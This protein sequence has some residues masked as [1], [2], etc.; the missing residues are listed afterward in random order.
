MRNWLDRPE[1]VD[2]AVEGC[3]HPMTLWDIYCEG[4]SYLTVVSIERF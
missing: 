3:Y 1:H 4:H 2:C